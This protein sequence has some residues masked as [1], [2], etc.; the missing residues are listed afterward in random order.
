M[1]ARATALGLTRLPDN[2]DERRFAVVEGWIHLPQ[3]GSW[4]KLNA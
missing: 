2:D 1:T 3:D 4:A